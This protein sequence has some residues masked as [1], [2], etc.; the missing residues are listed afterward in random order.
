MVVLGNVVFDL[1]H[2]PR[3][4]ALEGEGLRGCKV[5]FEF[6]ISDFVVATGSSEII[7]SLRMSARLVV[8]GIWDFGVV[9]TEI[10]EALG[11]TQNPKSDIRN[12]KLRS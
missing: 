3:S 6:R 7:D 8:K 1:C 5:N 4:V 2:L 10:K 11:Q 9:L 12:P